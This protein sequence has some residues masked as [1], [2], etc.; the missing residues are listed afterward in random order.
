MKTVR[1]SGVNA[2][3]LKDMNMSLISTSLKRSGRATSRDLSA[4]T[5]LS[6][7]TV[8]S[9][10]QV[11][12]ARGAVLSGDL[13]PSSGGR[14][15]REYVF[16]ERYQLVLVLFT[17][18]VSGINTLCVRVADLY[19]TVIHAHDSPFRDESFASF[20][21]AIDDCISRFPAIAAIAFGLPGIEYQ[22][23]IV[24][25]DYKNLVNAPIIPHFT[26]RYQ[27]PVLCENDVNAAA[28]G[29]GFLSGSYASEVYIYVPVKYPPGSGIRIN[30]SIVRG[31]RNFAGEIGWLPVG[32]S[33]GTR[34][35]VSDVDAVCT[36]LAK[37]VTS[38]T[39]VIAPDSVV[40]FGE[41]LELAH[42]ARIREKTVALLPEGMVPELSLASDFTADYERGLI[43]LAL[44]R[45]DA[46]VTQTSISVHPH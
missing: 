16:N 23:S 39:A 32:A 31:K 10:L 34:E 24:W 8:N 15:A 35:F 7:M 22:G 19:G 13:V 17:R 20:E 46:G 27:L 29:R 45:L 6:M 4:A 11:L 42:L 18:E 5:G 14:P 43:G 3:D 26:E 28:F 25:L 37:V 36:A 40:L 12:L 41:F 1:E 44:G 9:L 33:W 21:T 38:L 2:L 30:G